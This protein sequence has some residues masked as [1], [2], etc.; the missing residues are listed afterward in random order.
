ML[1][2]SK[3]HFVSLFALILLL[4]A[5][6]NAQAWSGP[7]QAPPN[8]NVSPPINVGT[9]DQ[10]KNA[11]LSVNAF[12]VFGSAYVQNNL[13][14]GVPSPTQALD[15]GGTVQATAFVYSSDVRLKSSIQPLTSASRILSLEP[16]TFTWNRSGHS[17]IGVIAQDVEALFPEFVQEGTDGMKSVDYAKLVV[18]LLGVV[19]E[20]Q[21]EIDALKARLDAAGL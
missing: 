2:L 1:V 21:K 18:P 3:K 7:T 11:G 14:V 5:I 17:D 6:A 4:V 10:V 15:V 8:G 9:T 19:R 12:T 13:G 16:K 20:Q